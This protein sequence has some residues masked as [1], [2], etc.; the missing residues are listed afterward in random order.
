MSKVF[1][2]FIMENEAS[3]L[4]IATQEFNF[5][6]KRIRE[7]RLSVCDKVIK[8][9]GYTGQEIASNELCDWL[10]ENKPVV[11]KAKTTRQSNKLAA[12]TMT[13]QAAQKRDEMQVLGDGTYIVTAAQNNTLPHT[14]FAQL[15]EMADTL[16]AKLLVM[17]MHYNKTAFSAAVE[18]EK[19][20]FD[21][22]VV[23]Y[24]LECDAWLG[25]FGGV[26]LATSANVLPT[27]K[28][29]VGAARMLNA[30]E[31]VTIVASPRQ[32]LE[33]LPVM[34]DQNK[35]QVWTTGAC[36][37]YNYTDSRAG[38]EAETAHKFGALIINVVAGKA[39]VRNVLQ[40]PDGSLLDQ[41]TFDRSQHVDIV[42]GD[43]H[44]EREDVAMTQKTLDWMNLF[45]V[46][47]VAL[48]D[49]LHFE[50][51]SHHNRKSGNHLYKM[52]AMGKT[53][54]KDLSTVIDVVNKYADVA[55]SVYM[56]ESN[57]NS[58][59]D[60][61]LDDS[62]YNPK[63][64]AT[65]AKLYYLLNWAVCNNI[66]NGNDFNA[67]QI[68]MEQ[69]TEQAGLPFIASNIVFG[70]MD[71][72]EVWN[73]NEVSQHGHKGQNGSFGSTKLFGKWRMQMI[74]GHTHSPTISGDCYTVGVTASLKQ[75]YNRG[76]ASSWDHAHVIILPNGVAQMTFMN[77][78]QF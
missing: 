15:Q 54:K 20:Y 77:W 63:H 38:A 3:I 9:L 60:N 31:A 78:L 74:T 68:A 57:H 53:V 18:D 52:A 50:T 66:D 59:I 12:N 29:P 24:M 43:I 16:S 41:T 22:S 35:R 70:D 71:N 62:S 65:D 49:V 47:R 4:D 19:E 76:G 33:C 55:N 10:L 26:R 73:G 28:N 37:A 21:A 7:S 25:G 42:L 32:D 58:A 69:C 27:A 39:S 61:W 44:A 67:L 23:D 5:Y 36:T 64:D 56:V 6:G 8:Q 75:G 51:K 13:G 46:D 48:H 72:S 45:N 1:T 17:P 11:E 14:V 34:Q 2:R 40:A 30:G